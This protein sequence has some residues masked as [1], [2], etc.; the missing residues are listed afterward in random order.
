MADPPETAPA[1]GQPEEQ[2]SADLEAHGFTPQASPIPVTDPAQDGLVQKQSPAGGT[3]AR[4]GTKV[5][6]RIG[7]FSGGD[8]TTTDTTTTP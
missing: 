3:S 8:T 1:A 5:I 6:L 4:P 7:T 2:A